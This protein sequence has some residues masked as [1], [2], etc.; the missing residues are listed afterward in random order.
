M[1]ISIP[2]SWQPLLKAETDKLYFKELL[3]FLDDDYNQTICYPPQPYIFEALKLC[4][5]HN[6]SVVIIGQD[7]YHG[8]GQA[9]GLAFSVNDGLKFPPSLKN[10]LKE[11]ATDTGTEIPFSGNLCRWAKQGVLLL[12]STLTVRHGKPGSHQGKGWE[13][14]T[15]AIITA[16]ASRYEHLVFL[17]WGNAA[18]QKT[19]LIDRSQH[20]ILAS[21]HPSPLSANKQKWFGN[22]HF[23]QANEY[24]LLKGK[25]PVVW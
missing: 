7:P 2:A 24:L 3:T 10:I 14:F 20:L 11:V 25:T 22:R 8:P 6:V 12:N 9:H 19:K 15:D 18:R 1:V 5:P 4:A 17:V 21:C 13:L 16:I 23:T